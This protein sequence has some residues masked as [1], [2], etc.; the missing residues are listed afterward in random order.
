MQNPALN[1]I[2]CFWWLRDSFC[3][4]FASTY[5][6]FYHNPLKR[7]ACHFLFTHPLRITALSDSNLKMVWILYFELCCTGD[8]NHHRF[9][10]VSHSQLGPHLA[11]WYISLLER[12]LLSL[13]WLPWLFWTEVQSHFSFNGCT[14]NT[15]IKNWQ[16]EWSYEK[17]KITS[18]RFESDL[19]YVVAALQLCVLRPT[20]VKPEVRFNLFSI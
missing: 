18:L 2:S 19:E 8:S 5:F 11:V 9:A 12:Q 16:W 7:Q 3:W 13:F 1:D 10:S 14:V 6:F 20:K 17:I 4:F 15:E